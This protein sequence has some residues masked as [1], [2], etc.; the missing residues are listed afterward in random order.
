MLFYLLFLQA[1]VSGSK[2]PA[3]DGQLIFL[4]AGKAYLVY[5]LHNTTVL[6]CEFMMTCL[7]VGPIV[8]VILFLEFLVPYTVHVLPY[9]FFR[10]VD[11]TVK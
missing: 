1:P 2:K 4:T 5:Y 11:Y 3:E 9:P 8:Y 6:N 10:S 7:V